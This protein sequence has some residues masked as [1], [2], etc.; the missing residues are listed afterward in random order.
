MNGIIYCRKST[1]REDKQ[2]ISLDHQRENCK[3][4]A[5]KYKLEIVDLFEESRSAKME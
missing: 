4:T 3:R 1:D 2:A 5:G